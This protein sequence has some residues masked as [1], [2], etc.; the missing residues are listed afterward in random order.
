[1][2]EAGVA[3]GAVIDDTQGETLGFNQ[4]ITQQLRKEKFSSI[5]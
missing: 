3:P 2:A 1:M 4:E 5:S